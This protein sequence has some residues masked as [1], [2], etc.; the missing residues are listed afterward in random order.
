M[1]GIGLGFSFGFSVGS[2]ANLDPDA[3]AFI[4]SS[5]ATESAAINSWVTQVKAAGL[6]SFIRAWPMRSGQNAGTGATVYGLGGLNAA[7]GVLTGSPLWQANG[8][9][10]LLAS[11]QYMTAAISSFSG[12]YSVGAA[13]TMLTTG[14]G[15][16][17]IVAIN[18]VSAADSVQ[19]NDA[20]TSTIGGGHREVAGATYVAVPNQAYTIDVPAFTVQGWDG[21]ATAR[22]NTNGANVS[23]ATPAFGGAVTPFRV[24]ARADV[25]TIGQNKRVAFAFYTSG[26]GGTDAEHET[27]RTIYKATLG[28]GL[29]LP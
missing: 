17:V 14:V 3:A 10:F 18:G 5:G 8:V 21:S 20:P 7:N 22:R 12:R 23:V 29:G 4:A 19:I 9:Q 16:S 15:G 11:G 13:A 6:W 2:S 24:N 25:G 27:L 1:S 26:A 28:A